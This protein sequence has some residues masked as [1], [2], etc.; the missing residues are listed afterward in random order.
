MPED[1]LVEIR[2]ELAIHGGVSHPSI[3]R[4]HR[5]YSSDHVCHAVMELLSGG[6][7]F[8]RIVERSKLSEAEAADVAIQILDALSY[9][10]SQ[11][12]LHRDVKLE[13]ILFEVRG[14]SRVKLIDF[15]YATRFEDGAKVTGKYG[16]L[17]YTAPEVLQ[18]HAYDERADIWSVGSVVYAMLLGRTLFD[19]D[20]S[21]VR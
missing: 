17:R 13:N 19:G 7:L 15:G 10:H 3:A 6:E 14:G 16:S 9:L 12:I 2:S 4:L 8:E 11:N 21:E 1:R 5:V 18:G 20:E